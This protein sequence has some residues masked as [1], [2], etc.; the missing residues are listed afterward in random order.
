MIIKYDQVITRTKD[1][2]DR[3]QT[4]VYDKSLKKYIDEGA[5]HLRAVGPNG[6]FIVSCCEIPIECGRAKLDNFF[7]EFVAARFP[8]GC[9]CG[10]T[11]EDGTLESVLDTQTGNRCGCVDWYVSKEVLTNFK[12][13][14]VS[15]SGLTN[16]FNIQG[17]QMIFPPSITATSVVVWCKR[18]NVDE[19][20]LMILNEDWE[21]ALAHYAATM[22]MEKYFKEYPPAM[23]ARA[24]RRWNAGC[25]K[26]RGAGKVAQF[27][28]TKQAITQIVNSILYDKWSVGIF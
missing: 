8:T 19:N 9:M 18:K 24:N 28:L 2:I 25:N 12:G 17:G 21:Y 6:C 26:I 7:E 5:R 10:S 14:G 1:I 20:G 27:K 11:S 4:S 13:E 23:A 3:E 22:H 15:C 16:L